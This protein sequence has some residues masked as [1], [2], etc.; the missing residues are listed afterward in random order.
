M[1]YA[2][3]G[4]TEKLQK[5]GLTPARHSANLNRPECG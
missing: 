1:F 4:L 3:N 5:F 2:A